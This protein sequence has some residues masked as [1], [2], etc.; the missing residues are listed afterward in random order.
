MKRT[1]TES[2]M[3]FDVTRRTFLKG[4]AALG[5]VIVLDPMLAFGATPPEGYPT[6][7]LNHIVP[8]AA[9]GGFDRSS[10]IASG[11]WEKKLG[12]PIK[13]SYL[14]GASTLIGIG[15]MLTMAD[16]Y[17][18]SITTI[19]MLYLAIALQKPKFG[20]KDLA[21]VGNLATDPNHLMVHKDAP[22]KTP[23]EFVE[24]GRKAKSP[25][26]I[27]T[28]HP[29]AE[30]TL[31][32]K[33]FI[34]LTGIN[35]EVVAFDGGSKARNALAGKHVDACCGPMFGSLNVREMVRS[36]IIFQDTNPVPNLWP[37]GQPARE[38]LHIDMPHS[39][40]P[41]SILC[42]RAVVTNYPERYKFLVDTFRETVEGNEIKKAGEKSGLTP[43]LDYWSP[44][45][46]DKFVEN[47]D[48]VF[49]K[50]GHL[51]KA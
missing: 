25:L 2:P 33:I 40:D 17:A 46:C 35:A 29:T 44:E 14:P 28:S 43:F 50:Y 8:A 49:K 41:Y 39:Q 32:S 48:A 22:W 20:W 12:V 7:P 37:G 19:S 47:Y 21:F 4:A 18:T 51:L 3:E 38:A 5:G 45:K 15:K 6:K 10:R 13:F 9:G 30:N 31:A 27:S 23:Q 34:Q 1:Y 36:L 42:P 26:K 11:P 16:G 24:A